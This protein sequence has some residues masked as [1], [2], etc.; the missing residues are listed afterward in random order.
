MCKAG[1]KITSNPNLVAAF[2]GGSITRGTGSTGY[3]RIDYVSLFSSFVSSLSPKAIFT[4]AGAG[5]TTNA[6]MVK[7]HFLLE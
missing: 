2:V 6:Y 7:L 3:G 4:N 1:E 5:G